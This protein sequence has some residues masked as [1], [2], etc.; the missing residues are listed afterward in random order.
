MTVRCRGCGGTLTNSRT[1]A[2]RA[3]F[4]SPNGSRL[5]V[6]HRHRAD[7]QPPPQIG[8][9]RG[10]WRRIDARAPALT[11]S[12]R[13]RD[14]SGPADRGQPVTTRH[15]ADAERPD[16]LLDLRRRRRPGPS[17]AGPP[18]RR[19]RPPRSPP[20]C[21]SRRAARTAAPGSRPGRCC[22]TWSASVPA[23]AA[24]VSYLQ[25]GD[26]DEVLHGDVALGVGQAALGASVRSTFHRSSSAGPV[27]RCVHRAADGEH[28]GARAV[29]RRS[30]APGRRPA[31]R[32][33]SPSPRA[34]PGPAGR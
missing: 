1:D 28:R 16:R 19:S 4:R 6:A 8:H 26:T 21:R 11:A 18:G 30:A 31:P 29:R 13:A 22:S 23:T 12:G 9:T 2:K 20:P 10:P 33:C 15:L 5:F 24:A 14:L 25:R 7:R 17:P 3:D 34:A 32:R 27:T